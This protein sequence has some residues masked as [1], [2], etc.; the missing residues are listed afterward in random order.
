MREDRRCL[1]FEA[2]EGAERPSTG[3]RL[4]I[5]DGVEIMGWEHQ[6]LIV[7]GKKPIYDGETI[8]GTAETWGFVEEDAM[9]KEGFLSVDRLQELLDTYEPDVIVIHEE[10]DVVSMVP[11]VTVRWCLSKELPFFFWDAAC[12]HLWELGY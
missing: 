3:L 5:P 11:S 8:V 9:Q 7:S 12:D 2:G 1:L 4:R 6:S 10:G